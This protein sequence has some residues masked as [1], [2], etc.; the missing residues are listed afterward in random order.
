[1]LAERWPFLVLVVFGIGLSAVCAGLETGL[2]TINRVRLRVRAGRGVRSAKRLVHELEHPE[3]ALITLLIGNNVANYLGTL[4]VVGLLEYAG[5]GPWSVLGLNAVILIPVLFI[6]AETLPKDLFRTFTD[7][8]TYSFAWSLATARIGLTALGILP[9]ISAAIQVCS[10]FR[11]SQQNLTSPR[12]RMLSLLQEG[13]G[14]G[15]LSQEQGDLLSRAMR[16]RECTVATEMIRWNH[17]SVMPIDATA[18]QREARMRESDHGRFPVVASNGEVCGI[19]RTTDALIAPS[20]STESLQTP[21]LWLAGTLP[22]LEALRQM[23]EAQVQLAIVKPL[24]SGSPQGIIAL[25]DL[26][27]PL[28]GEV[29]DW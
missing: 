1:M 25:K 3:R 4:G 26:V 2:Y 24:K 9:L 11:S 27:E 12:E 14:S 7:R 15:V 23:R 20:R 10:G 28:I 17:V 13:V 29:H 5:F 19:L 18:L 16:L 8:W 21:A 6:F 22:A